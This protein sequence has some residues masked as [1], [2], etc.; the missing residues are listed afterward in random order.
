[1][2]DDLPRLARL[3]RATTAFLEAQGAADA[4]GLHECT[5][6]DSPA[7]LRD[8]RP[9]REG[10]GLLVFNSIGT[11]YLS[12]GEYASLREGMAQAL[13]PWGERGFWVEYERARGVK[14]GPLEL[15]VHQSIDG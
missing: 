13:A 4:P 12:Q 3:D 1:W 5:F 9:A 15:S 10:E 8:H 7:W 11:V 14:D 2:A 6:A